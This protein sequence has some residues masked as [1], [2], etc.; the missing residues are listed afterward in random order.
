MSDL[1]ANL[2]APYKQQADPKEAVPGKQA[3][4]FYLISQ[5]V[6]NLICIFILTL[7]ISGLVS[8]ALMSLAVWMEIDSAVRLLTL[9]FVNAGILILILPSTICHFGL[10][11]G[12]PQWEAFFK[13]DKRWLTIGLIIF[14]IALGMGI[15][16]S[17]TGGPLFIFIPPLNL[18]AVGI[19]LAAIFALS[20]RSLQRGSVHRNWGILSFGLTVTPV[21]IMVLE[22][23]LIVT[24]VGAV[25]FVLLR[26]GTDVMLTLNRLQVRLSNNGMNPE[27]IIRILQPYMRYPLTYYLLIS[28][29]CGFVPLLEELLK[30]LGCWFL[31]NRRLSPQEGFTAGVLSGLAFSMVESMNALT[32]VMNSGWGI[33]VVMRI[34]TALLHTGTSGLIGWALAGCIQDGRYLRLAVSYLTAVIFHGVWNLMVVL[35][36]I[37]S[38]SKDDSLLI[39]MGNTP[40]I[41]LIVLTVTMGAFLYGSNR[42]LSKQNALP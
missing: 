6:I 29:M 19:P 10:L 18:L 20:T 41:G 15:F 8:G 4:R 32:M 39:T 7:G 23:L 3:G 12:K 33:S 37:N 17:T 1:H 36:L 16:F 40:Y 5:L 22:T 42:L 30:P 13:P 38:F 11:I 2:Q 26:G 31:L 9:A 14:P 34:G 24:L 21:I 35:S 25:V 27:G 28:I